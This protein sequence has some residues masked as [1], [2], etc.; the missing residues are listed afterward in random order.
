MKKYSKLIIALLFVVGVFAFFKFNLSSYLT[1]DYLKAQSAQFRNFYSQN[2]VLTIAAYMGVYIMITAL[3]LPGAAIMTLAGGA[4][5]GLPVGI[6][7]VSF[8]ST[9]GATLAFLVSRFLLHDW[10]QRKFSSKLKVINEGFAKEGRFYLFTLRLIPAVPF[11]VINLV[12]GLLPISI[13]SFYLTSQIG[14]LAGTIVYVNAGTALGNLNSLSGI[15]SP[16]LIGSFVLLGLFPL[17]AKKVLNSYKDRKYLRRYKKPKSYDY[18]LIVIGGGSAGLVTAYIAAAAQSK[19][20]LIEKHK[21]GGDCLNTGC[22]PSKSLLRSAKFLADVKKSAQLGIAKASVDFE[23][24]D[25]M[26]RVQKIVKKIEPHDSMERYRS[27]GVECFDGSAQI[28]SPYEVEVNGKVLT[29]KSIVIA[30]GAGPAIPPIKGLSDMQ[31]LTSDNIWSLRERPKK[32]LVLGGGPIGTELAQAF[33]RL[34]S[35]VIQLEKAPRLLAREDIEISKLVQDKMIEDGVRLLVD[36]EAKEFFSKDGKNYCRAESLGQ[37]VEIEFDRVLV[38]LGR[39]ANTKGF[40]LEDLEIKLSPQGTVQANELLAT[41]YPNIYVCGDVTGPYQFTH[42][43]AHQAWYCAVNSMLRPFYSFKVDYR[44]IPW[45]TYT[46]PEVA[47]V[48][49]NELE[50]KEKNIEYEVTTFDMSGQDRAIT[51]GADYG[52]VKV[53]TPPGKD[54]ILGV[55]IVGLHAGDILAEFVLAMKY[56]LGLNKIL[57]TI[58]VYPTLAEA[59]KSVAGQWRKNHVSP[60]T[61]KWARAF[62]NWRRN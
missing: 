20:A 13:L 27:L 50:A 7:V 40:G 49:L 10:V 43:A 22:V 18:N 4:L 3:S 26:E 15:L 9:V 54:K 11:F 38:A 14:M 56:N 58:H 28:K 46:A 39:K 61:L 17:I 5:F 1:L 12:M 35:E 47:R 42:T 33:Q 57:G 2:P 36:H 59:N 45:A 62:N 32:L 48:G 30:S 25:V 53:L 19:V 41:N 52:L 31:P 16:E 23:F 55:T 21:M 51:E 37:I 8:A 6:I 44:V 24:A 60:T 29:T 34:G